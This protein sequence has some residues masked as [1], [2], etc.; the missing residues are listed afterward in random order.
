MKERPI[1]MHQRSVLGIFEGRKTQTRRIMKLQPQSEHVVWSFSEGHSGLG[2]Y[3]WEEEYP[4][5]GAVLRKCP[6]GIPG[7]RLWVRENWMAGCALYGTKKVQMCVYLDSNGK[8]G[9]DDR[10]APNIPET[11]RSNAMLWKKKPSIH[12]PRWASRLTLEIT[13]IRVE[14]VQD[15]SDADCIKEGIQVDACNHAIREDDDI[16]WGSAQGLFAELWDDTN[17][18]GAWARNDWTWV[19]DFKKV[20]P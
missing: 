16:A 19:V 17:G 20:T 7:D 5:D 15:I 13:G 8:P 18:K 1:L 4:E 3:C 6:Y 12:M 11:T 2:W 9:P 14:R 10:M